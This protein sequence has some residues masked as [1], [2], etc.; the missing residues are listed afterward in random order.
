VIELQSNLMN[1]SSMQPEE[2][3]RICAE[4]GH[5]PEWSEFIRRFHPLITRVAV[6][7]AQIWGESSPSVVDDLVQETYLKLCAEDC[8]LLRSFQPHQPGAIY[9][10]IKMVTANVV[11]DHFKAS[12][13][14]KRGSGRAA[15]DVEDIGERARKTG[16]RSATDQQTIERSILIQQIDQHLT[17]SIPS[18]DL[19]RNRLIFWLYYRDG[20]TAKA[21]ASIPGVGLTPKGVESLLLRLTRL[22]RSGLAGFG[23]EPDA[24]KGLRRVESF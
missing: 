2:L 3:V 8:R 22:V 11:H 12:H 5:A 21:I 10:Y 4:G 1:Y 16:A 18:V 6:R 14:A 9:G 20:L 15:E 24:K 17:K 23:D 7:T 13:A 19:R